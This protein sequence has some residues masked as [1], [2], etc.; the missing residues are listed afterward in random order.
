[1]RITMVLIL[2]LASVLSVV[3]PGTVYAF[4]A[5]WVNFPDKECHSERRSTH[6][7]PTGA[8]TPS[9]YDSFRDLYKFD[10]VCVADEFNVDLPINSNGGD[11]I[12]Y[13][14]HLHLAASLDTRVR[15]LAGQELYK[16]GPDALADPRIPRDQKLARARELIRIYSSNF[17]PF[18]FF[19]NDA[20]FPEMPAGEAAVPLGNCEAPRPEHYSGVLRG[21]SPPVWDRGHFASGN[22]HIFARTVTVGDDRRRFS[23]E[24]SGDPHFCAPEPPHPAEDGD[25]SC[26]SLHRTPAD[27]ARCNALANAW[28]P[29]EAWA[30][31]KGRINRFP[32][33]TSGAMGGRGG[34]GAILVPY[35]A[36]CVDRSNDQQ[37]GLNAPGGI[38]GDAGSIYLYPIAG[39][40]LNDDLEPDWDKFDWWY[41]NLLEH[42]TVRGGLPGSSRIIRSPTARTAADYPLNACTSFADEGEWPVA[43][44]GKSGE[45]FSRS[46]SPAQALLAL[47]QLLSFKDATLDYN[48]EELA[49]RAATT[50]KVIALSYVGFV[51]RRFLDILRQEQ[52]RYLEELTNYLFSTGVVTEEYPVS[53]NFSPTTARMKPLADSMFSTMNE[54]MY[55]QPVEGFTRPSAL[56][57]RSG[58]VLNLD[59]AS[60]LTDWYHLQTRIDSANQAYLTADI[61]RL[62]TDAVQRLGELRGSV[63]RQEYKAT[64]GEM[65]SALADL[66]KKLAENKSLVS[67]APS[68]GKFAGGVSKMV[69]GMMSD[70]YA[71]VGKGAIQTYEGY[72]EIS[73]HFASAPPDSERAKLRFEIDRTQSLVQQMAIA[74]AGERERYLV[75][76]G[77]AISDVFDAQL[78]RGA[79]SGARLLMTRDLIKLSLMSY[80]GASQRDHAGLRQNLQAVRDLVAA[81]SRRTSE[82][83]FGDTAGACAAFPYNPLR[84]FKVP[85]ADERRVVRIRAPSAMPL[86]LPL[87]IIDSSAGEVVIDSHGSF[88]KIDDVVVEPV[89]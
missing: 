14:N 8:Q 25:E 45:V 39:G 49:D 10:I 7:E 21:A 42:T 63:L 52:L 75:D 23:A 57:V 33:I 61:R 31:R 18:E 30:Q 54:F 41:A 36:G 76:R 85:A 1:M 56:F 2:W 35:R 20:V 15:V 4:Q 9:N 71:E 29:Y 38:G 74:L 83:H 89:K 70:D 66:E 64:A 80:Y 37:G 72:Q 5:G 68:V 62:L 12:I 53:Y 55:L 44:A 79:L 27:E 46:V 32:L 51:E 78:N 16:S 3:M 26:F 24:F 40:T 47:H 67:A 34:P 28:A 73:D 60:R 43:A 82:F 77:I 84:C 59:S 17:F 11:I 58:G 65:R 13:A 88:T 86:S 22:I 48:L 19:P 6:S 50:G 69:G 87:Q 81:Q